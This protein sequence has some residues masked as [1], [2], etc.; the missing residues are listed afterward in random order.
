[1]DEFGGPSHETIKNLADIEKKKEEISEKQKLK[2]KSVG[3]FSL[4]AKDLF[5]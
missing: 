2:F 1:M 5:T 4:P 3:A